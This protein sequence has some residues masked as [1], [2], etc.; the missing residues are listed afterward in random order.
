[1]CAS[2]VLNDVLTFPKAFEMLIIGKRDALVGQDKDN[3]LSRCAFLVFGRSGRRRA[4]SRKHDVSV[5]QDEK[6]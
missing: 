1:M 5:F 6:E 2:S 3:R 4:G